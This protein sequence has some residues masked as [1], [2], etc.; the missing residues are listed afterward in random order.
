MAGIALSALCW[1]LR[2]W[3]E[4][5]STTKSRTQQKIYLFVEVV[6]SVHSS[7]I[8]KSQH[9]QQWQS[10]ERGQSVCFIELIHTRVYNYDFRTAAGALQIPGALKSLRCTMSPNCRGKNLSKSV[11]SI[12]VYFFSRSLFRSDINSPLE[13]YIIL[14][15]VPV[16]L[17]FHLNAQIIIFNCPTHTRG[18]LSCVIVRLSCSELLCNKFNVDAM[19]CWRFFWN[20][21]LTLP[22][23]QTRFGVMLLS[24]GVHDVCVFWIDFRRVHDWANLNWHEK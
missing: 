18:N 10:P 5:V 15:V 12:F 6:V 9:S 24:G 22:P 13:R 20:L 21:K 2:A 8:S 23:Q 4:T 17:D 1:A 7:A 14:C 11:E 16:I 3:R 19:F